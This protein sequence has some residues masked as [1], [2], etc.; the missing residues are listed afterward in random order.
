MCPIIEQPIRIQARR[1]TNNDLRCNSCDETFASATN[2]QRKALENLPFQPRQFL[3][4]MH[5]G[6]TKCTTHKRSDRTIVCDCS[7]GNMV[8]CT[9]TKCVLYMRWHRQ[10]SSSDMHGTNVGLVR[11]F[12]YVKTTAADELSPD[13]GERAQASTTRSYV[14]LPQTTRELPFTVL[15]W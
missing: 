6:K 11:S 3:V 10:S 13:R 15:H 8:L 2:R 5:L 7:A 1:F 14:L 12:V 9:Y 4:P